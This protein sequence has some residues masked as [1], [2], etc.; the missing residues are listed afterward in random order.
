VTTEQGDRVIALLESIAR[1][2]GARVPATRR[3]MSAE[4]VRAWGDLNRGARRDADWAP[5]DP[6]PAGGTP[7]E[8]FFGRKPGRSV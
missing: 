1:K 8:E 7:P 6:P 4:E 5:G 2:L 3:E